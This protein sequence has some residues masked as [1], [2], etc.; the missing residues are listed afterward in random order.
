MNQV[1][2]SVKALLK[3]Q[4]KFL[5]LQ[6][7]LHR[8]TVWDLPGGKIEYGETPQAA[9]LREIREE[10]DLQATVGPSVGLWWF[11]SKQHQHQV[12]CHTFLCEV[13]GECQIDFSKN[14]AD[15]HFAS[16]RWLTI[17][18]ALVSQEV[19][20]EESLRE[21]LEKVKTL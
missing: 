19:V 11:Y 20:L 1:V 5:F 14:P 10:L 13:V 16:Y 12:I 3:H 9:L 17:E 15:E 18:E 8:E 6:E 21:M 7:K 4:G 2:T